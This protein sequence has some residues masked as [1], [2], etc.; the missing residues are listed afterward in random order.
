MS[1]Y[2][3]VNWIIPGMLA[4]N[5]INLIVG[6]PE[7]RKSFVLLDLAVAL[8]AGAPWLGRFECQKKRVMVIDQERPKVEMQRRLKALIAGRGMSPNALEGT[9]LPVVGTTIRLDNVRSYESLCRRI[10]NDRP[11]VLL[12]DSFKAFQ[13]K[14]ITNNTDMQAV[15]ES[16]KQLRMRYGLTI[17]FLFHENKGAYMRD[18]EGQAVTNET[19]AGAAVLSEVP[20]G[21]FVVQKH[22]A[23]S[24]LIHHTKSSY[25]PKIAPVMVRVVDK[26]ADK[27]VI[28]VEAF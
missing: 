11:E 2:Q 24:S 10:E 8:A 23:A 25:G 13:S 20:E 19:V 18:R 22:D 28:T 17:V 27:S 21:I 4:E 6:L 15:M 5:T 14:E 12:V 7:C 1:D 9:L 3:P 16:V 26:A